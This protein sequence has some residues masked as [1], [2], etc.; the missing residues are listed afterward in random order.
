MTPH[1]LIAPARLAGAQLLRAQSDERL[2]DLVRA[3][4]DAA[5]EAIVARYRRALLRYCS[6]FLSEARAEDVVQTTFVNALS[7]M[8]SSR[9]EL[10][11]RPWLYRI[12]HN[13]SL[14]ALR[15]RALAHEELPEHFDG[16][17][18]PDQTFEKGERFRDVVAAVGA[19]PDRQRDAV[20]LREI[21]GRSYDEIASELGVSNG[22]CASCSTAPATR[23]APARRQSLPSACSPACRGR[24]RVRAWSPASRRSARAAPAQLRSPRSAQPRWSREPWWGASRALR[25]AA[26]TRGALGMTVAA[27]PQDRRRARPSAHAMALAPSVQGSPLRMTGRTGTV[28]PAAAA[29]RTAAVPVTAIRA[30]TS[31]TPPRETHRVPEVVSPPIL[32]A[33]ATRSIRRSTTRGPAR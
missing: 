3:G 1:A 22:P 13:T 20:V 6:G 15:D 18:P 2:V 16:I 11:L 23:C 26:S 9:G 19:L 25:P 8:R 5:F 30:M 33:R 31:T 10:E 24:R 7:S 12:A 27:R 17:E 14:N 32:R 29:A 28:A 21:E 4:N